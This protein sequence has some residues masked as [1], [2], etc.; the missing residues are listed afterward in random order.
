MK[1]RIFKVVYFIFVF[2]FFIPGFINAQELPSE[3]ISGDVRYK[4][5]SGIGRQE[6]VERQDPSNVVKSQ[7]RYFVW[8]TRR[9]AGI[10][11]YASTIYYATSNDGIHWQEKGQ[12]LGK[13]NPGDWDSFG[14]ITPYVTHINNIWYLFYTGTGDKQFQGDNTLRHIGLAVSES[15]HGPWRKLGDNPILSPGKSKEAWD[16]VLVDDAHFIV[17]NG[18]F[19]LYF[20]GRNKQDNPHDS[21]WGLAI[22]QF[23]TGPYKKFKNN[24]ILKKAHTVCVWPHRQGVG[25]L[26]DI[27]NTIQYAPDGIHFQKAK[28]IERVATGCGPYDP[29]AFTDTNYGKGISWGIAQ[30]RDPSPIHLVRFECDLKVE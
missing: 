20:K 6:G 8:Y 26:V 18:N 1:K 10:H 7:N 24:P 22:A 2:L 15:P 5:I 12:A 30:S 16:A 9:K 14:V 17:R 21:K 4:K 13:G 23:P 19:W 3:L 28:D 25:A 11:P 29:Q 27:T